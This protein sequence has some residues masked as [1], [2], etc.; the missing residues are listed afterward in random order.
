MFFKILF[1]RRGREAYIT[2]YVFIVHVSVLDMRKNK[3]NSQKEKKLFVN[4]DFVFL[5]IY[6]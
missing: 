1:S 5:F 3:A 2:N 6:I 4:H